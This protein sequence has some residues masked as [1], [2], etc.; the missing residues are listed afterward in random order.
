MKGVSLICNEYS[1][2]FSVAYGYNDFN[3]TVKKHCSSSLGY[4][5]WTF[6]KA[7]FLQDKVLLMDIG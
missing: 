2:P 7:G 5:I 4:W 6:D 1:P 3:R